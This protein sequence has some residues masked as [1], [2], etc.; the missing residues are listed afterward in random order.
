MCD[1]STKRKKLKTHFEKHFQCSVLMIPFVQ[2]EGGKKKKGKGAATA[3]V[4]N[5]PVSLR[6]GDTLGLK[7]CLP[8]SFLHHSSLTCL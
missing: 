3:N 5:S 4:K 6:D 8:L 1:Y 7:V 2:K